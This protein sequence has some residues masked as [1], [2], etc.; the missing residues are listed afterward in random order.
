VKLKN[1]KKYH[2][3]TQ[4]KLFAVGFLVT[5][6]SLSGGTRAGADPAETASCANC[7]L[8][9]SAS[10]SV[11][12]GP[13]SNNSGN[14]SQVNNKLQHAFNLGDGSPPAFHPQLGF[15]TGVPTPVAVPTLGSL[16][17]AMPQAS[18]SSRCAVNPD[19]GFL[20]CS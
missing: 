4:F 15:S 20:S 5:L 6:A 17:T 9:A 14:I 7:A 16:S 8:L 2:A 12:N 18:F 13:G 3:L 19:S 11:V 1:L 10:Q